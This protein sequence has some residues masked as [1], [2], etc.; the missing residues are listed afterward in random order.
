M[1]KGNIDIQILEDKVT[2][3]QKICIFLYQKI[4]EIK[5][6]NNFKN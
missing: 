1:Q 3:L 5:N 6:D 2:K 4:E